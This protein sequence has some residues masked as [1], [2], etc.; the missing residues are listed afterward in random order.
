M[1]I[2]NVNDRMM[3]FSHIHHRAPNL[4]CPICFP[5]G[6]SGLSENNRLWWENQVRKLERSVMAEEQAG[7]YFL[8]RAER[9]ALSD[10][11]K[12]FAASICNG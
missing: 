2:V 3:Q 10:A 4:D 8:A 11:K 1:A 9:H 12:K 6:G 5:A 7:D